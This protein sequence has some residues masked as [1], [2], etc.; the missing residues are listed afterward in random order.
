MEMEVI[1]S[2]VYLAAFKIQCNAT[3]KGKKLSLGGMSADKHL[4]LARQVAQY[5]PSTF[6]PAQKC[7]RFIN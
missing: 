2:K 6:L 4:K 5:C 3:H 7:L 1:M